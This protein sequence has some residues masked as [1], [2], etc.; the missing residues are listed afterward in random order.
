MFKVEL[1]LYL[2]TVYEYVQSRTLG[3]V[4]HTLQLSKARSNLANAVITTYVFCLFVF[5]F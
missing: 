5:V 1:Y 2:Y 4:Q 3:W